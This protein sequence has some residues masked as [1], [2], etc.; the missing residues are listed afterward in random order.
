MGGRQ[1]ERWVD[2]H[3]LTDTTPDRQPRDVTFADDER[4]MTLQYLPAWSRGVQPR[5]SFTITYPLDFTTLSS[6]FGELLRRAAG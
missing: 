5:A 3:V 6:R 1:R 4:A 2:V